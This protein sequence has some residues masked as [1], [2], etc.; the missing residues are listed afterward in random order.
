MDFFSIVEGPLLWI[1]S[2]VFLAGLLLRFAFFLSSIIRRNSR[3]EAKEQIAIFSTLGRFFLPLHK[4]FTKKP[5][6]ATLRY[7]FHGCLFVVPIWLSGHIVLWS[8]SRFE[9]DWMALPDAWADW[10]TLILLALAA[11]FIVR[12]LILKDL[13]QS[14]SFLDILLI[15]ITAL[16][17]LTGYFLTHGTLESIAF[18]GSNMVIIH[19]L[20]GELMILMALFLFY[21]SRLNVQTCTGCAACVQNCPTETLEAHD[22]GNMRIFSYAHFQC[23]CCG[24][25]VGVC[26][27]GAA[28]LRHEI[29]AKRFFQVF[30]K[31]EIRSVELEACDRCGAYFAP[32]SQMGKISLI[33][34]SD[35]IK[36]CPNCRKTKLG[37]RLHQMSPWHRRAKES[38]ETLK[39]VQH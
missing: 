26:P 1:V 10:M 16:P 15:I 38:H 13:R 17:F 30:S 32:E 3:T 19:M 24:S 31:R 5:F 39:T 6:Y 18:L 23:I 14:S 25:C 2:F 35:C 22:K 4:A 8:E 36:C 12:R 28:E 37:E 34:D 7:I 20:S 29:N 11:Y 33:F 9:W 27:E 21:K